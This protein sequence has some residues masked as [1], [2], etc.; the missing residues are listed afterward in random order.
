VDPLL[1]AL[2]AGYILVHSYGMLRETI[3]IL[4]ESAPRDFDIDA[5]TETTERIAGVRNMHHV[6]VWR[7]DEHRVALEAH[8][9]V[10][11]IRELDALDRLKQRIK[12]RLHDQFAIDHA[13]LE[14]EH[15]RCTDADE[16]PAE[17]VHGCTPSTSGG[18]E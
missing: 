1:T 16:L 3:S 9:E 13:T 6:H 7:L 15:G 11:G 18:P 4:M 10:E 5:L 8:V 17:S 14:L 12:T 2:I